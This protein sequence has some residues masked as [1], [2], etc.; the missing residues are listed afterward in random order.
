MKLMMK[1]AE[2][3]TTQMAEGTITK[4]W[5][6]D[7]LRGFFMGRFV[8]LMLVLVALVWL[9][10][11]ADLRAQQ[12]IG[13]GPQG[14]ICAGPLGPGPCEAVRQYML[15]HPNGPGG[16]VNGPFGQV[17]NGPFG[18]GPCPSAPPPQGFSPQVIGNS[19]SGPICSGPLG[20]GPCAAVMQYL[21][22][23]PSGGTQPG[24]PMLYQPQTFSAMGQQAQQLGIQ[25]AMQSQGDLREFVACAQNQVVLPQAGQILVDCA[26]RSGGTTNGLLTCAGGN[27]LANQL[28]PEQQIAV[29]CV[30]QT[31]GQPYAAASCTATQLTLRELSKC[32]TNGVGGPDGCFGDNN[33]LVGQNGWTVRSFNNVVS[34]IQHGP[35]P[36]NDLVGS[37]GFVVRTFQ[38]IQS[39]IQNGPGPNNDLVGCNG[40][41]NRMFGGHC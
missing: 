40:F 32:V 39:D 29:Q 25:C 31:G 8:R 16:P 28:N 23:N 22:Q 3:T 5:E 18:P 17:C 10:L 36:T 38:N 34:D 4:A 11:P 7:G 24:A 2:V 9:H 33:D 26:A 19:P 14:P 30:V 21:Q 35:G 12:V 20:P 15:Q 41:V 6:D 13:N 27:L 1:L 37:N